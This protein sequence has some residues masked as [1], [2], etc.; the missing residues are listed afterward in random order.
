MMV[1]LVKA[2][3]YFPVVMYGC[4]SQTIKK[5]EY[6]RIYMFL[7]LLL[8]LFLLWCWRRCL[9]VPWIVRRSDQSILKKSVL[10]V[11]WKALCCNSSFSTLASSKK[12]LMLGKIEGRR[13][14]R[15]QSMRWLHGITNSMDMRLSKV[16][17]WVMDREAWPAAVHGIAKSQT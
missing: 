11:H 2:I 12:I 13:R 15:G 10:T 9:K 5:A 7:F 14:S 1:H 16:W 17:V 6:Q 4:E 8:L 3:Y